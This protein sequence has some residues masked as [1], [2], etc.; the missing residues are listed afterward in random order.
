MSV[1]FLGPI[2]I[3]MLLSSSLGGDVD[4][5]RFVSSDDFWKSQKVV[6]S[7][8]SMTGILSS[9]ETADIKDLVKQLGD[10]S[11][12]ARDAAAKKILAIGPIVIPQLQV[13]AKSS[14]AEV[15]TRARQLINTLGQA[16][17]QKGSRRLIAIRTLGEL[18]QRH[19]LPLLQ[20]LAKSQLPFEAHYASRA[21]ATIEGKTFQRPTIDPKL[22]QQDVSQLPFDCG[23]VGQI[24]LQ[25]KGN[26]KGKDR[27]DKQNKKT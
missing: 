8:E 3:L 14:D 22:L 15:A 2:E 24:R 5:L 10:D 17:K 12:Q 4:L 9:S 19:A 26:G 1:S 18:K 13:A 25:G 27:D 23:L 21:I 6:V 16:A 11:F 20:S 7:V